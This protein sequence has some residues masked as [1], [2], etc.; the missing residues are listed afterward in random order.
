MP[1]GSEMKKM[2]RQGDVL[3]VAVSKIPKGAKRCE[4]KNGRFVLA[5]GE[6]TGHCHTICEIDGSL[7]IDENNRLFLRTEAGCELLHQE[8]GPA[9]I[10]PG[11]HEVIR[12]REYAPEAIHN[13]SD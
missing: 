8:H 5:E 6:A 12:Q 2:V 4:P 3:L 11:I 9:P 13:V 1:R 7:F 10:D